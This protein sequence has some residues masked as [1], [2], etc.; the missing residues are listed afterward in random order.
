M[1]NENMQVENQEVEQDEAMENEAREMGWRPKEEFDGEE[2]KWV[3][4]KTFVERGEHIMPILRANNK[5]IKQDLLTREKE[6][7]TLKQS[8]ET[9]NKAIKA[10]QKSYTESTKQQVELAKK[11]LREQLKQAREIGDVDSELAIQEKLTDIRETSKEV[12]KEVESSSTKETQ[13]LAPEFVA[14]NKENPWFGDNTTPENRKRTRELLRIGEDLRE[15]GET[16][17][18]REYMDKCMAILLRREGKPAGKVVSK[19]E[20]SA[21]GARQGSHSGRAFDNLTKE[22]KAICH[23]DNDSFVGPGKMFKTVK[24]WEDHFA[25]Y[26]SEE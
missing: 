9:A 21:P 7:A 11:E 14:W 26:M 4:A 24:E 15:D 20:N 5:R 23:E 10:L 8:V 19:V 17:M 16:S 12:K 18:G 25:S 2:G 13:A 1:A 6:I 3:D 22:A